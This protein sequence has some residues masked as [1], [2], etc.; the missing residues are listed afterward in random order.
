MSVVLMPHQVAAIEGGPGGPGVRALLL[1]RGQDKKRHKRVLIVAATGTGKTN[2]FNELAR[3]GHEKTGKPA[4]FVV[5][6]KGL[7][8]QGA[9]SAEEFGLRVAF[10]HGSETGSGLL[11]Q[12]HLVV[13]T[14]Q[15]MATRLDR[16]EPGHFSGIFIDEAHFALGS[17]HRA[18]MDY[19]E[20]PVI[21]ATATPDRGDAVGLTEVFSGVAYRY[22]I[23]DAQAD[24]WLVDIRADRV[25]IPQMELDRVSIRGGDFNAAE[26]A[27]EIQRAGVITAIA[28][29]LVQRAGRRPTIVFTPDV[30]SAHA[31]AVAIRKYTA[32]GALA[33]DGSMREDELDGILREFDEGRCQFLVCC[34]IWST[35]FDRRKIACVALARPMT[36]RGRGLLCQMVGRGTRPD[37]VD[38]LAFYTAKTPADRKRL[39]AESPKRDVLVL[40]FYAN[41]QRHSLACPIDILGAALPPE[42]RLAAI[43]EM[44]PDRSLQEALEEARRKLIEATERMDA[45][46]DLR[47]RTVAAAV[48]DPIKALGS[49]SRGDPRGERATEGQCKALSKFGIK[50]PAHYSK[51][52]AGRL[53]KTL[54]ERAKAGLCSL[55][56]FEDLERAGV[57]VKTLRE[58][59]RDEAAS[60]LTEYR[61]NR[62]RR[63]DRW[64]LDPRLG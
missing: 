33:G 62:Q 3:R 12:P 6:R 15:T 51:K 14:V 23:P 53:L 54:A 30:A 58:M 52:E 20:C 9:A 57:P 25:L 56:Q 13:S 28:S 38:K 24:G 26:L 35:G 17:D 21:G 29:A 45:V 8:R 64:M 19:F 43:E 46:N 22:D 16:Y 1:G 41:T 27:E 34:E 44:R 59:S 7:M 37:P 32:A 31:M 11:E 40:D 42:L 63:P 10:E 2:V 5:H 4:L 39:I 36:E 55:R 48:F 50:D 49:A 18:V 60:L 47:F 61:S